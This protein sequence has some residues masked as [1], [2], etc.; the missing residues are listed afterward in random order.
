MRMNP[1]I[2]D[3]TNQDTPAAFNRLYEIKKSCGA[4]KAVLGIESRPPFPCG[5]IFSK[6]CLSASTP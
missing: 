2:T 4:P 6:K 1:P 5:E 3:K